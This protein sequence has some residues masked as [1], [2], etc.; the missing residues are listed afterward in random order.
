MEHGRVLQGINNIY[1]VQL[2]D[3]RI[4]Q[5]RIKGKVLSHA[6][7]EY[8]P[9]APGDQVQVAVH[10]PGEGEILSRLERYNSFVRWNNKREL[11]QAMAANVERVYCILSARQPDF[12]PRFLDRVFICAGNIPVSVVLNKRDLGVDDQTR[13]Y[14][15]YLSSLGYEIIELSAHDGDDAVFD[16]FATKLKH[17][18]SAFVGQSG[19]GKSTIIN[20]LIPHAGQKTAEVS[21]RYDRGRHTTNFARL[22]HS[23]EYEIIDTPG[24]REIEILIMDPVEIAQHFP[25]IVSYSSSCRFSGCLHL[26]EPG[27]AVRDLMENNE[28]SSMRYDSYRKLV[29]SMIERRKPL[30]YGV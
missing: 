10:T 13:S 2:E 24:V 14:L 27:C 17:R 7:Q 21:F 5:C 3:E 8:N 26:D 25:E 30:F 22:I 23:P 18:L 11:P 16:Q 19:V 12:R 15:D 28:V 20:R 29:Q 4:L 1:L 9:L 6:K